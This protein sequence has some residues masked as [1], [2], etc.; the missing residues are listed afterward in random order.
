MNSTDLFH[1]LKGI[2]EWGNHTNEIERM[3]IQKI[4]SVDEKQKKQKR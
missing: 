4:G 2:E 3:K 1:L